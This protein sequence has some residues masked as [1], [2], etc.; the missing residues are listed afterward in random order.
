MLPNTRPA[1]GD[2]GDRL[3]E[4]VK[5][6]ATDEYSLERVP[7]DETN[8]GFQGLESALSAAQDYSAQGATV[9]VWPAGQHPGEREAYAVAIGGEIYCKETTRPTDSPT[10]ALRSAMPWVF[11]DDGETTMEPGLTKREWLFGMALQGLLANPELVNGKPRELPQA[12]AQYADLSII[13][14][15]GQTLEEVMSQKPDT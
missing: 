8:L 11:T 1:E 6:F 3:D 13:A 9:Y 5:W 10:N 4:P 12:A 15:A 7:D 14:L 2:R